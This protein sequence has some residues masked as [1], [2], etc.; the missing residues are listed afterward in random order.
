MFLLHELSTD[1]DEFPDRKELL[2]ALEELDSGSCDAIKGTWTE[3]LTT[4]GALKDVELFSGVSLLDQFPLKCKI[5]RNFMPERT[6]VKVVVY[7][8][9]YRVS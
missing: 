5:S 2:Y 3:R 1:I 9:N 7:R 4:D 6:T 8:S